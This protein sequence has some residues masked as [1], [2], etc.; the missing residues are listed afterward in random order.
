[1]KLQRGFTLIEMLVVIGILGTLS[2]VAVGQYSQVSLR[3]KVE[4]GRS[5]VAQISLAVSRATGV[6]IPPL[7]VAQLQP[8]YY[9]FAVRRDER[10]QVLT[11]TGQPTPSIAGF[12]CAQMT[13]SD[14]GTWQFV[15]D[16]DGKC[17]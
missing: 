4:L 8:E 14:D 2:L 1:M 7:C 10:S 13:L 5:C 12:P 17:G 15:G 3:S 11:V 9:T 16:S 6:A